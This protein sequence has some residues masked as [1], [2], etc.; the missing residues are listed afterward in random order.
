MRIICI[1][2]FIKIC[3][4]ALEYFMYLENDPRWHRTSS[5]DF[6]SLIKVARLSPENKSN[7]HQFPINL[8]VIHKDLIAKFSSNKL[9][10]RWIRTTEENKITPPIRLEISIEKINELLKLKQICAAD[11][12]CL[13]SNSKQC[14]TKLCLQNC[15]FSSEH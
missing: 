13:D 1:K 7:K 10:S 5:L 15:L 11:I 12:R 4:L 8:V 3:Q 14:V 9:L 6:N 2:I